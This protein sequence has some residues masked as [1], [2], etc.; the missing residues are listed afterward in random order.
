[1]STLR[2]S[3]PDERRGRGT[4]RTEDIDVECDV[5]NEVVLE[6]E[7]VDEVDK[8]GRGIERERRPRGPLSSRGTSRLGRLDE[9]SVV[10]LVRDKK[11]GVNRRIFFV[12]IVSEL[13]CVTEIVGGVDSS[14]TASSFQGLGGLFRAADGGG[15][16]YE[17]SP[18]PTFLSHHSPSAL[19]PAAP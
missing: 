10:L 4:S 3:D 12:T 13:S 7:V 15:M 2:R 5:A 16:E 6:L 14:G 17:R 19:T 9:V 8:L 1:M 11:L 18:T